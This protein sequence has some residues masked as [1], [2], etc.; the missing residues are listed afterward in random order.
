VINIT[1]EQIVAR[2]AQ[3]DLLHWTP[4]PPKMEGPPPELDPKSSG[5]TPEWI[6]ETIL[7]PEE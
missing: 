3:T 1:P 4:P 6:E 5:K 2:Q 7:P